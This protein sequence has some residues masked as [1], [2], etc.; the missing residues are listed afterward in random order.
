MLGT[1]PRRALGARLEAKRSGSAVVDAAAADPAALFAE[2]PLL[3]GKRTGRR[4]LLHTHS[5]SK[6]EAPAESHRRQ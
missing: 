6:V 5:P 3:V 4:P 1:L 2:E